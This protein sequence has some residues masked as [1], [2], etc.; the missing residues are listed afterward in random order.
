MMLNMASKP[1]SSKDET[2]RMIRTHHNTGEVATLVGV[3]RKT[4]LNWVKDHPELEPPRS[5]SNYR[6]WHEADI[7]RLRTF[8][9]ERETNRGRSVA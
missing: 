6:R 9:R 4:V 7:A 2:R 1:V 5:T 3:T 8:I